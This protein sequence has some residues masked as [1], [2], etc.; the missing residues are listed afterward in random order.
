LFQQY[1]SPSVVSELLK[2]PKKINLGGEN[3]EVTVFFSDIRSFTTYCES[4]EASYVIEVLNEYLESMTRCIFK[5]Q[6]TIDKFVGDEI[7][8]IW[9]AP[10]D[11]ADHACCWDQL[12]ELRI[13]Q[14]K[15]RAQGKDIIDIGMGL[16]TGI[17]A[18]GNI[19]SSFR[20]D[21]TVMGDAVN[22]GA[23]LE[24]ETRHHGTLENPCYL[25]ISEFTYARVKDICKVKPLGPVKVKGKNLSVEI[26]EVTEVFF[27]S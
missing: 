4:H 21:Y 24:A 15:W 1:V 25:I 9:G 3:R 20:K 22:L 7:M 10:L 27:E 12:R 16:N 5:W 19:G 18:V 8:A 11:Q 17:V 26:Y 14:E 13:L 2:D 6:G 23:R